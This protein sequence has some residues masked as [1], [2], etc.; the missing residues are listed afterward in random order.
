MLRCQL[1]SVDIYTCGIWGKLGTGVQGVSLNSCAKSPP[2]RAM[3]FF[4]LCCFLRRGTE[5]LTLEWRDAE[6][7]T[8]QC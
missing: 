1:V 3:I 5:M 2:N 8:R 6:M 7:L 4:V